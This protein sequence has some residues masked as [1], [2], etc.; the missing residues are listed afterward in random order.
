[1]ELI[2]YKLVRMSEMRRILLV[3][4][5]D[6]SVAYESRFPHLGL[7]YL[8][9]S[10]RKHLPDAGLT[11][12]IAESNVRL[13][14]QE[15]RPHLVGISSV[16][17]NFEIAKQY[18]RHFA[19]QKIPV[20]LGGVHIS[21]LPQT[22]PHECALACLGESEA[23][24]VDVLRA[25][26]DNDLTT[27]RLA[28]IPGIAY[29][30]DDQLHHTAN[31]EMLS[32]LDDL[33]QPARDLLHIRPHTYMFTSR[34][35]PFRCI[36]C[37][38]SRYWKNLRFFSAEY[39]V[40]EIER[41]KR[42][43]KVRMIS[44]FDDLFTAKLARVE[45][46]VRLL[47]K[48][49]LLGKIR[50]TCNCRADTVTPELARLLVRMGFVSV[51]MGLESGNEPSL[52]FLKGERAT[53]A[54]NSKAINDLK[55]AGLHVNASFV[56]GSPQETQE[57]ILETYNFIRHSR[58]DLFD[59]YLLTPLPGTPVWDL[60]KKR[61]LVSDDWSNWARL[62]VNAYRH[63]EQAI[64]LSEAM[65]ADE[66][67][68]L[69]RKFIRMRWWRNTSR[70]WNHPLRGEVPRMAWKLFQDWSNRMLRRAVPLYRRRASD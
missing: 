30:Q 7:G 42:D 63:P 24:F 26:C 59:V 62:D 9:A 4:A 52:V 50:F 41:L 67:L 22:L 2:V 1:M 12:R 55:N 6:A 53:V 45:E 23:T 47:E 64:I 18:V 13:V 65:R 56:I 60:A 35:C 5:C 37:S 58:L 38:S 14:A 29:W 3:N 70:V 15:F 68:A 49:G 11:F 20:V 25:L 32:N 21:A 17:Q 48:R 8:I 51:G 44:F 54:Q 33:P 28:E 36:F 40:D 19:E 16:S 34:G 66:L 31:R 10:A 61:G 46:I 69:Y 57:Q 43:Y 39:V 27:A